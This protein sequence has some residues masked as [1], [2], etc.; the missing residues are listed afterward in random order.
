VYVTIMHLPGLNTPCYDWGLARTPRRPWPASPI[1]QPEIALRL[2]GAGD[3]AYTA[4]G[5]IR[6][7]DRQGISTLRHA[8]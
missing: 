5:K 3:A 7:L 2:F 1:Y 4:T 6:G 8:S